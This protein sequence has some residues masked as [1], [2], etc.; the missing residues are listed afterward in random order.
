MGATLGLD[1]EGAV[2]PRHR[3]RPRS[4]PAEKGSATHLPLRERVVAANPRPGEGGVAAE[5]HTFVILGLDPRIAVRPLTAGKLRA[6]LPLRTLGA[7][8]IVYSGTL[9]VRRNPRNMS[10]TSLKGSIDADFADLR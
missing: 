9:R 6:F 2:G 1:P 7:A 10:R 4:R 5:P 3:G 8:H